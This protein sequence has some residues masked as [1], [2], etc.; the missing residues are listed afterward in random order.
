MVAL[1]FLFEQELAL[2][3]MKNNEDG[4]GGRLPS[5]EE[6]VFISRLR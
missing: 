3:V 2:G 5:G 6:E 4:S 1:V